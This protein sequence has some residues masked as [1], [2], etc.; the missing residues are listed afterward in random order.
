MQ[1]NLLIVMMPSDNSELTKIIKLQ[2]LCGPIFLIQIF[3]IQNNSLSLSFS[4]D[5]SNRNFKILTPKTICVRCSNG[6][7]KHHLALGKIIILYGNKVFPENI[8]IL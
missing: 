4:L 8:M 2:K 7:P 5:Q 3:E 6:T 1:P